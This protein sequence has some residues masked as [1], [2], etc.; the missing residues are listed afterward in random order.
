MK[1]KLY[2]IILILMIFSLMMGLISCKKPDLKDKDPDEQTEEIT[3][4][5]IIEN[6]TFY[7]AKNSTGSKKYVKEVV[8][9]WNYKTAAATTT[10]GIVHG[11]IDLSK[12]DIFNEEKKKFS[13][14]NTLA[15]PGIDPE[16][17][18]EKDDNTKLQDT[19]SLIMAS[20]KEANSL[21]YKN[22]SDYKLEKNT[23]Y[24]LQFS[25]YTDIDLTN[26]PEDEKQYKGARIIVDGGVYAEFD[27]I[28]TNGKWEKY[29][30]YIEGSNFDDSRTIK[31]RLWLGHGPDTIKSK[32][33]KYLTKGAAIFDNIICTKVT[34][35]DYNSV[36]ESDK[37]Q[38]ETMIYPDMKFEQQSEL[39]VNSSKDYFYSFR[40]GS[41]SSNN[42][43][44]YTLVTGKTGLNADKP[45]VDKP[46]L[47]I[48][49]M[50]KL[51]R[52]DPEKEGGAR[53]INTYST[54][55]SKTSFVAPDYSDFM[56]NS[57]E[58]KLEGRGTLSENKALMIF[59]DTLS[60][61]G[62][63]SKKELLIK[64]NKYY[65]ISVWAY[66]WSI[67]LPT[68][69]ESVTGKEPTEPSEDKPTDAAI[70]AAEE[71]ML[72]AEAEKYFGNL[73]PEEIAELSQE[74]QDRI[75]A[76]SD[77]RKAEINALDA[78]GK[79]NLLTIYQDLKEDYDDLVDLKEEW[80]DYDE[81]K[82]NYDEKY[83]DYME[84]YYQWRDSNSITTGDDSYELQPYA[85]FKIT[86]AGDVDP[87]ETD[88]V[89][90]WKQ[91]T[92]KVKGNQLSDRKVNLE[93]WFGEGSKYD[94]TSL[95]LGGVL[96]DN[97]TINET[98]TG[99]NDYI[100]LTPFSE[101]DIESGNYDVGNLIDTT[102]EIKFSDDETINDNDYWEKELLDGA[103]KTDKEFMNFAIVD[104]ESYPIT[105]K[106]TATGNSVTKYYNLLKM[107]NTDY[108]ASLLRFRKTKE[109]HAN[110]CYR[111][112]FW[113][114][115]TDIDDSLGA[116]MELMSKESG[117]ADDLN[118][119][120]SIDSFNEE[121][122][123]EV[124]F[125][126]K[127]DTLLTN[128]VSL[129]FTMGSGDKFDTS[130]YIKG[131]LFISALTIK[132]IEYS[133]YNASTKSGD[134]TKSYAFSNT[135]SSSSDNLTNAN[136]GGIDLE[137]LD[138]EEIN[139]EGK[140]IGV[141]PTKSWTIPS[142]DTLTSNSYN[143][144][145]IKNETIDDKK[146]VTWKH[147]E[148][149]DGERPDGYE[150][151]VKDTEK[152]GEDVDSLYVGYIADDNYY[153][154]EGEGD[155]KE[156][157][158]RFEIKSKAKG[159]FVVK[160]VSSTGVSKESS[161]LANTYK[162]ESLPAEFTEYTATPK[163][164]S[165]IGTI[166]YKTYNNKQYENIFN[167]SDYISPYET[168]LIMTSNYK[169]RGNVIASSKSLSSNSYYELSIW[170]NT[171][172]GAKASIT[173]DDISDVLSTRDATNYI[174]YVNQDTEGKWK[175]YRF[176]IKTDSQ[177]SNIKLKL[178]IGN[179]YVKGRNGTEDSGTKIYGDD[180]LTKGTILFDNV[181][182]TKL[183]EEQFEK[184]STT[185][186]VNSE[187][188]E[189]S[190][191]YYLEN[192]HFSPYEMVYENNLFAYKVLTYT[193]DSFDSFT[194][195]KVTEEFDSDGKYKEGFNLGNV[196]NAYKW[197][198][199]TDGK[200]TD[201]DRLY[202]VYSY[203]DIN[204]DG[205]DNPLI[206]ND[207]NQNPFADFL[208]DDFNLAT[209]IKGSGN[210]A[211][212]MSN[213]VK[214]GQRYKL[215]NSR[216]LSDGK[217]YKLTIK[218]KTLLPD[219]KYAELRYM[220]G[221]DDD[222]YIVIKL[223]SSNQ[224]N[225]NDFATYTVYIYNEDSTTKSPKWSF[226]LGGD[227]DDEKVKGMLVIDDVE[228]TEIEKTV[229]DAQKGIFDKLSDTQKTD[230]SEQFYQYKKSETDT[231]KDDEDKDKTDDK[232]SIFDRGEVWWLVSS[233]V[234][235]AIIIFALAAT[236]IK[237]YRKKHPKKV[238]GENK[239]KT[240]KVID[241]PNKQNEK[242]DIVTDDEFIDKQEE[243]KPAYIQRVLPKKKKKKKK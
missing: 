214:N 184:K 45:T 205:S 69:P 29:E 235:G 84:K 136:F 236:I 226:N 86:G 131:S 57:G 115:T 164:E 199:A 11:V 129:K 41:N 208:P 25:V 195:K 44:N 55:H 60:G 133:E 8:S 70:T 102:G 191:E 23:Y 122:W 183:E 85:Q 88:V 150:V 213:L 233:V 28:N 127:G 113:A 19:N 181:Q 58:Y 197:Y 77:E 91:Y 80:D 89:G 126:I 141:A 194:P 215:E 92:F 163:T 234:I 239:V 241:V 173:F 201:A 202:G 165:K 212:V 107:A 155:A 79:A 148:N 123:K 125:Y 32:P 224:E 83:A 4:T 35:E 81:D 67:P 124:V 65:E 9:N 74:K 187:G 130:K 72:V 46:Y 37:L 189:V 38:K 169:V 138:E 145:T 190:A 171:L 94:Y 120:A 158:Y 99:N 203:L 149:A 225:Y 20:T 33:N 53:F 15:Y 95:M 229:Y 151:Y 219:G 104:D 43:T 192:E 90:E 40:S 71:A 110:K 135:A 62:F 108:T 227:S 106:D 216:S 222:N 175:Q 2:T 159:N 42:A 119:V 118:S 66:V 238:K 59:H 64:K 73:T 217:Y 96:F 31:I 3:R 117:S 17:P 50:S 167:N 54:D 174:G 162:E 52:F 166:N 211:L 204:G 87:I 97:L 21:Y 132:E 180:A 143:K 98:S 140:L 198:K 243:E 101:E 232:K 193:K 16:T 103:V 188:E 153:K 76:I 34:Q 47:G 82:E 1:K 240:E 218:A 154:E 209:F 182:L 27:N 22:S 13:I 121:E 210:N 111:F 170:V 147:V 14:N 207:T 12:K 56:T 172:N 109:I 237:R 220:Y 112:S 156:R 230:S 176:Y 206:T 223:N 100:E 161:T 137:D 49:D 30:V 18:Y 39:S 142:T 134:K 75:N 196:P 68:P 179:P 116:K 63:T 6:G 157:H 10:E 128:E 221:G 51:F 178:S 160:A 200:D 114:K 93:F 231:D 185:T 228:F 168:M 152:N 186:Y 36:I 144:P 61:A 139:E 78:T 5:Q 24:K 146:Y 7:N 26:V 177:S 48:V 105:I 242:E